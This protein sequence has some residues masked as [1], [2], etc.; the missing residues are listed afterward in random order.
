M[1]HNS[2]GRCVGLL[3]GLGVGAAVH[4]YQELARAHETAGVPLHLMMAHADMHRV[5]GYVKQGATVELARYLAG[6]IGQ[7]RAGGAEIAVLP[8]VTPHLC[9]RDLLPITPLPMVNLL[10]SVSEGIRERGLHRVALFGT[11]YTIET[12]LFDS[13]QGVDVVTPRKDEVEYI[14]DTY[15][16]LASDGIGADEQRIGLTR[17]AQTL[18][19]REQLDAIVLA[20]TDLA[21][22]FNDSNT[23]FPYVDCARLHIASIM[24]SLFDRSAG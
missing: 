18:C 22:L 17:L 7:L 23:D 10:E 11:R 16:K 19:E 13:M 9:I 12:R 6:L 1:N 24:R 4:Y 3:G 15:F 21:L 14:H 2:Q 5:V 20:G 8:A